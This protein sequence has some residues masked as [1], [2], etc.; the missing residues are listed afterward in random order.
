MSERPID[1][2]GGSELFDDYD[3]TAQLRINSPSATE[4]V[5]LYLRS[6]QQPS[7]TAP[8]QPAALPAPPRAL[9]PGM[10]VVAQSQPRSQFAPMSPVATQAPRH[11]RPQQQPRMPKREWYRRRSVVTL[12]AATVIAGVA[13]GFVPPLRRSTVA[14]AGGVGAGYE[15]SKDALAAHRLEAQ[16]PDP[17]VSSAQIPIPDTSEKINGLYSLKIDPNGSVQPQGKN[18]I[19]VKLIPTDGVYDK[20]FGDAPSSVTFA[21]YYNALR[22]SADATANAAMCDDLTRVVDSAIGKPYAVMPAGS[23]MNSELLKNS[24]NAYRL[25]PNGSAKDDPDKPNTYVSFTDDKGVDQQVVTCSVE[26]KK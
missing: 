24:E 10:S 1:I 14:V 20:Y 22:S 6:R 19:R 2:F 11:S 13:A 3:A 18:I 4:A 26:V 8:P 16:L 12:L 23:M 5:P 17:V 15:Y 7:Y 21:S 25:T 9:P